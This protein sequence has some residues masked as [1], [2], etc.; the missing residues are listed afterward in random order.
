MALNPDNVRVGNTGAIYVAPKGTDGPADAD[1]EWPGT[2]VE[3]GAVSP[4]GVNENYS[5]DSTDLR[6][7][8][9]GMTVRTVVTGSTATVSFTLVETKTDVLELFHKGSVVD[10]DTGIIH[11]IGG[12]ISDPRTFGIDVIDGD[13]VVRLLIHNG[14]ITTRGQV[15]YANGSLV[16]YPVT[17]TCQPVQIEVDEDDFQPVVITKMSPALVVSGT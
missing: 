9:N 15:P 7:W 1:A 16:A 4:D 3:L 2:F 13:E 5:D 8:Q 10:E 17:V 6:I 11:V 12:A 14:E